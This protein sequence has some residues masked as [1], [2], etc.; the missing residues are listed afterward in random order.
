M[1]GWGRVGYTCGDARQAGSANVRS[2][3]SLAQSIM[4]QVQ[5]FALFLFGYTRRRPSIVRPGRILSELSGSYPAEVSQR[6]KDAGAGE[7]AD[8][9]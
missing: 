7:E 1:D 2:H 3:T 6:L 9:G 4:A 8:E 5:A